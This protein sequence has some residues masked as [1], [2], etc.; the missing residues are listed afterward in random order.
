MRRRRN[1]GREGG[2]KEKDRRREGK[3]ER[4]GKMERNSP[5]SAS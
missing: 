4:E 5:D 1:A 2:R 3:K